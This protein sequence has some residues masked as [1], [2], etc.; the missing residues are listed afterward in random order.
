MTAAAVPAVGGKLGAAQVE[1]AQLAAVQKRPVAVAA[2]AAAIAT[3]DAATGAAAA[4]AV[5]GVGDVAPV[6]VAHS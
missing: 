1:N 4:A 6:V 3:D 2:A 5:H